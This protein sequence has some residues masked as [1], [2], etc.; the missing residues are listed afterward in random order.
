MTN[1]TSLKPPGPTADERQLGVEPEG[2]APEPVRAHDQAGL[3]VREASKN[4]GERVIL[5]AADLRVPPGGSAWVGG[6][7]GVGKTTLLRIIAG[8]V[9]PDRGHVSLDG[10]DPHRDR[11]RYQSMLGFLSA[12][13]RGLYAR[14]TVRQNMELWA[15]LALLSRS[16]CAASIEAA[17]AA[18]ELTD[19]LDS[20]A[21]RLSLGQRQR[22]RLSLAFLHSPRLVLLD[23]PANSM[24]DDGMALIAAAIEGLH[25]RG[26]MAIWCAP[27]RPPL[28]Q[29]VA[30][31]VLR[32][33]RLWEDR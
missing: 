27:N 20:R 9:A 13:D 3:V 5:D 32:E 15:R 25:R 19:L 33:G 22:L 29:L 26:G 6:R 4:W 8:L 30:G 1:P 23:E 2:S 28:D 17:S 31:Y 18:F 12:G 14:L 16:A 11:R 24:D 10:L 21:D 7:N